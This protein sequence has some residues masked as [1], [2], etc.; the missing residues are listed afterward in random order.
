M[1]A[2]FFISLPFVAS[3]EDNVTKTSLPTS[4]EGP[5]IKDVLI[6]SSKGMLPYPSDCVDCLQSII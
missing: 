2:Y 1:S 6:D 4:S 3:E 5:F